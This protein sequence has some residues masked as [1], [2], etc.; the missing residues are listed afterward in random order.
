MIQNGDLR[1]SSIGILVS[2]PVP[3]HPVC[4]AL[5]LNKIFTPFW[6]ATHKLV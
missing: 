1:I 3:E 2:I 5:N 6:H 4:H